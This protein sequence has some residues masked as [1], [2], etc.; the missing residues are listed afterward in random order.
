ML[1][2]RMYIWVIIFYYQFFSHFIGNHFF[3]HFSHFIGNQFFNPLSSKHD[4][5]SDISSLS[6]KWTVHLVLIERCILFLNVDFRNKKIP[7][8]NMN[9]FIGFEFFF[10]D[11]FLFMYV[12]YFM[13]VCYHFITQFN[14][15]L[16]SVKFLLL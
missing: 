9:I 11:I 7:C 16:N 1:G 4:I 13:Y 15:I 8:M 14:N 3:S 10:L 5:S 6:L 12:G 2:S